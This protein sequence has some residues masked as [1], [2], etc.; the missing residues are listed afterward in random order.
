MRCSSAGAC[1]FLTAIATILVA[2]AGRSGGPVQREKDLDASTD[3]RTGDAEEALPPGVAYVVGAY[4]CCEKGT[5]DACCAPGEACGPYRECSPVGG[6]A[7]GK[8]ICSTCCAGLKLID[9]ATVTDGRCVPSNDVDSNFCA[10][11]GDGSCR[12]DQGENKCNC[13]E[14][15]H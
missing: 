3:T 9:G 5:G 2:C 6:W 15:C 7:S 13:P 14:D 4:K 1:L 11:C 12:A 10:A 8:L